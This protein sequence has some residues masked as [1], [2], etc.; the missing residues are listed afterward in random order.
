MDERYICIDLENLESINTF[1]LVSFYCIR[2]N[3]IKKCCKNWNCL[4]SLMPWS[5]EVSMARWIASDIG[6]LSY[7]RA[8]SICYCGDIVS[9]I[10]ECGF[11]FISIVVSQ[12]CC[13]SWTLWSATIFECHWNV[14]KRCCYWMWTLWKAK[15]SKQGPNNFGQRI[16]EWWWIICWH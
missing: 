7:V 2:N 14:V 13:Y 8:S 6:P 4:L 15:A 12:C 16:G 5:L 11:H 3:W 10:I 9:V 1:F